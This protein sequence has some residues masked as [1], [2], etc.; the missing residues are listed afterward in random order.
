MLMRKAADP[1]PL[2]QLDW[3]LVTPSAAKVKMSKPMTTCR[4]TTTS[5][6]ITMAH[7]ASVKEVVE[8]SMLAVRG[9]TTDSNWRGLM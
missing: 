2:G 7:L 1:A 5:C 8:E 3:C 6:P 9:K 4:H